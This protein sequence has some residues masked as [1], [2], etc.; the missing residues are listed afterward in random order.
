MIG[1]EWFSGINSDVLSFKGF[2]ERGIRE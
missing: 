1:G 2:E